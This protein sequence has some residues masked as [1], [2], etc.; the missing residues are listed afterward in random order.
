MHNMSL[1]TWSNRPPR[2][3]CTVRDKKL[4]KSMGTRLLPV[5][6]ASTLWANQRAEFMQFDWMAGPLWTILRIVLQ[7]LSP[8]AEL[9]VAWQRLYIVWY[10]RSLGRLVHVLCVNVHLRAS[11]SDANRFCCYLWVLH[12]GSV[13][14]DMWT[15]SVVCSSGRWMKEGGVVFRWKQSFPAAGFGGTVL[16]RTEV[17]HARRSLL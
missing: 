3:F 14:P 10:K 8:A 13:P 11:N 2:F 9:L 1:R 7:A 15:K 17:A 5:T 6:T 12:F 4:G 16:V